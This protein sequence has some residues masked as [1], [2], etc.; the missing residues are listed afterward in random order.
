MTLQTQSY[1]QTKNLIDSS[2][3]ILFVNENKLSNFHNH[4]IV[5]YKWLGAILTSQEQ[6]CIWNKNSTIQWF[7]RYLWFW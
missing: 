4:T 1:N 6:G 5:V 2:E 7:L 3:E